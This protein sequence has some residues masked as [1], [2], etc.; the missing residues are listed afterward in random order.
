MTCYLFKIGLSKGYLIGIQ[1]DTWR[2][3]LSAASFRI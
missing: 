1:S 2:L 3:L